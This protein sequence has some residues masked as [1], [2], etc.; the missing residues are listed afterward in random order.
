MCYASPGPRCQ[1]HAQERHDAIQAKTQETWKKVREAEDGMKAME[2]NGSTET[3]KYE[4]LAKKHG[5]LHGEWI[6]SSEKQKEA[7]KEID[8][9]R[10]GIKDLTQKIAESMDGDG[11]TD[12]AMHRMGLLQREKEGKRL[13]NERMLAYDKEKETVD[14]RSPSPYGDAEGIQTLT[15]R[16]KKIKAKYDA[17]SSYGERSELY[18]KYQVA[19]KARDHAVKTREY[20]SKG[21]VNPYKASLKTNQANLKESVAAHKEASDSLKKLNDDRQQMLER[22][23][24]VERS[25]RKNK[26]TTPSRYS[27]AA[28]RQIA[29]YEAE[30]NEHY[31]NHVMPAVKK[32]A[33]ARKTMNIHSFNVSRADKGKAEI[34]RT[35][36]YVARAS[37]GYGEPGRHGMPRYSGD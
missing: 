20:A 36:A 24:E 35:E 34:A 22:V 11:S 8:A 3:K 9:T 18:S 14:G 10:G 15:S 1:G 28:K 37:E 12:A 29:Q 32:E 5:E 26:R 33:E 17:S 21:I 23:R 2:A 4:R 6:K 19:K 30:N 27:V 31:H 13:Y 25:E 16:M 7:K